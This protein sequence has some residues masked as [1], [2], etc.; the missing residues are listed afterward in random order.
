VTSSSRKAWRKRV[1]VMGRS[2]GVPEALTVGT[3]GAL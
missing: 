1:S 2:E 3:E